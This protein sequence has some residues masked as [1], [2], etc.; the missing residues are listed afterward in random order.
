[1]GTSLSTILLKIIS[2]LKYLYLIILLGIT[3]LGIVIAISSSTPIRT[4]L[5]IRAST[6]IETLRYLVIEKKTTLEL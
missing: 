2:S 1:M 3:P 5:A 4:T 6:Q